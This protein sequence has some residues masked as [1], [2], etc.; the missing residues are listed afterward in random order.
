VPAEGSAVVSGF[1]PLPVMKW[2]DKFLLVANRSRSALWSA[3]PGRRGTRRGAS[4]VWA[5]NLIDTEKIGGVVG[6][7]TLYLR[8]AGLD[9]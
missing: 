6:S 2:P 5:G 9:H 4:L 8:L 3:P 1:L 7:N